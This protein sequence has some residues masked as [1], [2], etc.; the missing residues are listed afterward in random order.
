MA[1]KP[2][3][4]AWEIGESIDNL[5]L[6]GV[7]LPEN[8]PRIVEIHDLLDHLAQSDLDK[9]MQLRALLVHM[10]G[11]LARAMAIDDQRQAGDPINRLVILS[12][13]SHCMEAQALYKEHC[14]PDGGLF[15][16]TVFY[17]IACGAFHTLANF[18]RRARD[19]R[20]DKLESIDW[21]KFYMVD[22]LLTEFGISDEDS[23]KLMAT[24]GAV[25]ID[26][27]YMF[28]GESPHFDVIDVPGELRAVH[29]TYRIAATAASAVNIYLDF[30]ARLMDKGQ[31]IP[32]GLH[33]SFEGIA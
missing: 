22:K 3:T 15:T 4:T 17:A 18:A 25:L 5:I 33:I 24:A 6:P 9:S 8:D 30:I 28:L 32:P 26:H 11:D 20:F 27:G 1:I 19:L 23:G 14:R 7:L 2:Q 29:V 21:E 31:T 12:N 16:S 13:Y 10:T